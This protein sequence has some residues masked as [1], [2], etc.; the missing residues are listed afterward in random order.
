MAQDNGIILPR[1]LS[2]LHLFIPLWRQHIVCFISVRFPVLAEN[3]MVKKTLNTVI[4]QCDKYYY[5]FK[6]R[7]LLNHA[8]GL[9][10]VLTGQE[11]HFKGSNI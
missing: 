5:G 1:I 3:I 2:I 11:R 7:V 9:K 4:M 8:G 10:R 6:Y